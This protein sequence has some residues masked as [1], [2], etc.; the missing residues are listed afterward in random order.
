[1]VVSSTV[2]ALGEALEAVE[3]ELALEAGELGLLEVLG[4]DVID[5]LLG[6]VHDKGTTVWLPGNDTGQ[7]IR[8]NLVEES[9]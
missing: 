9:V 1:M 7:T 4:H 2:R 3:V 8:L 6:L 5:K